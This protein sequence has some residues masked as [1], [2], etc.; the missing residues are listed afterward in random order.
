MREAICPKVEAELKLAFFKSMIILSMGK[1][2]KEKLKKKKGWVMEG[3]SNRWV[4]GDFIVVQAQFL[5]T[6]L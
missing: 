2:T 4:V 3:L 1:S 6:I 5:K